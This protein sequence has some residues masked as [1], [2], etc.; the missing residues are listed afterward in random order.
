MGSKLKMVN[1]ITTGGS[2]EKNSKFVDRL[3][4]SEGETDGRTAFFEIPLEDITPRSVN[5]FRQSRI[6]KLAKSIR[7]TNNRLIHPITVVKAEDL[8]KDSEILA[9]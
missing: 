7:N 5:Q 9:A 4:N 8:P 2:F 6:E 1:D 3:L